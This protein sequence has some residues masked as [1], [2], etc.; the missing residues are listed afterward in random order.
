MEFSD[1]HALSDES[2][3]HQEMAWQ[4]ELTG[5]LLR[6]RLGKL[7][8][9][10]S[11]RGVRRSVARAQTVLTSREREAGLSLGALKEKY[12]ASYV[13]PSPA[14]SNVEGTDFLKS[15]LDGSGQAS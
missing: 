11:L 8:N 14:S 6:H 12:R 10:A 4:D 9:T 2:L 3:V 15:L 13:R 7:V 5:A 1:I